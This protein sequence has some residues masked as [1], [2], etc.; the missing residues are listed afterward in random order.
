MSDEK[1]SLREKVRA[2]KDRQLATNAARNITNEVKRWSNAWQEAGD[3]WPWELLQNARDTA[4]SN[5]RTLKASFSFEG[6]HLIFT[7]DGG[8]FS[9]DDI[10]ALILGGSAK[11]YD[12][13]ALTGRFGTG[14][15]VT[16][17]IS[18]RVSISGQSE[19]GSFFQ[20]DF[21]RRGN[22]ADIEE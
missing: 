5:K 18:P 15:L 8:P 21:D 20:M 7:H 17:A 10:T 22:Q 12:S 14:F 9:F 19:G 4:V 16:H 11:I 2:R 3:R 1:E 6:A 13:S